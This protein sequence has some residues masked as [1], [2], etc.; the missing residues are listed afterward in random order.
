MSH[1]SSTG[2]SDLES[3]L[4]TT[5]LLDLGMGLGFALTALDHE[6]LG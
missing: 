1:H 3:G 6:H 5:G 4:L 2:L